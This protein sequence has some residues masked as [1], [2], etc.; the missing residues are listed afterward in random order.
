M[1]ACEDPGRLARDAY[2]YLHVPIVAGIIAVAV[3]DDLLITEPQR[4]LHGVGLAMVVGGPA[5]FLAG[6][7][8]FRLRLIGTAD[9]ARL[10][11]VAVLVLVA[12][13]GSRVSA[14]AL[15]AAVAGLIGA[16][17]IWEL[18]RPAHGAPGRRLTATADVVRTLV[19]RRQ[20][21]PQQEATP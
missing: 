8:L 16:L 4:A 11:V 14:L 10:S 3:G 18:R 19:D 20:L 9:P 5:L 2:T 17:A 12:P 7:S 13:L 6:E 21:E 1:S 15:S